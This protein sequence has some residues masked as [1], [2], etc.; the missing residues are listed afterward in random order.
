MRIAIDYTSAI[1]QWAGIGRY[2]RNLVAAL[3]DQVLL[4]GG[5]LLET[6]AG[7]IEEGVDGSLTPEERVDAPHGVLASATIHSR[8]SNASGRRIARPAGVRR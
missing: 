5:A 1:A 4:S 6:R 7:A 2:T 3:A 8:N